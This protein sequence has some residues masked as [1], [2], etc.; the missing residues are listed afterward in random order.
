VDRLAIGEQDDAKVTTFH[1]LDLHPASDTT[2]SLNLLSQGVGYRALEPLIQDRG[3][4]RTLSDLEEVSGE[5]H[6]TT[7]PKSQ[8]AFAEQGNATSDDYG[9]ATGT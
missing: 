5:F 2:V 1:L 6:A 4:V 7:V 8:T 9:T 3:P